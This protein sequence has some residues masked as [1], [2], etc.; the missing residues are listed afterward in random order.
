MLANRLKLNDK[1]Y[2]IIPDEAWVTYIFA[3]SVCVCVV[4]VCM[5][6]RRTYSYT[7]LARNLNFGLSILQ[8]IPRK[9]FFFI[10]MRRFYMDHIFWCR[11]L[12]K[13]F[14]IRKRG[15]TVMK[16]PKTIV[17]SQVKVIS[18]LIK[19]ANWLQVIFRNIISIFLLFGPISWT[20]TSGWQGV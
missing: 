4:Y 17:Y 10:M 1:E 11:N 9:H 8:V 5:W 18:F 14:C 2:S 20:S 15:H 16:W 13:G 6:T 12:W 3:Q 19:F 7:V